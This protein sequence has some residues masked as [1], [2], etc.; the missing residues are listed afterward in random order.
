[1]SLQQLQRSNVWELRDR[2]IQV[3]TAHSP[4]QA[5][6]VRLQDFTLK[7]R[8]DLDT[9]DQRLLL[10]LSQHLLLRKVC[11][12][13]NNRIGVVFQLPG[14]VQSRIISWTSLKIVLPSNFPS[15]LRRRNL[16]YYKCFMSERFSFWSNLIQY[17]PYVCSASWKKA[18]FLHF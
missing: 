6:L 16:T 3:T 15:Q 9:T 11:F 1:M 18:L 13:K 8:Y 4:S 5:V 10:S 2:L 14:F 17:R 12:W 7:Q